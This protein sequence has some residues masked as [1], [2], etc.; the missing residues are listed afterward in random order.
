MAGRHRSFD[1]EVVL[2]TTMKVFWRNG[3]AGTSMSDLT[4]ATGLTKPSL[5]AAYGNKEA[6]FS[7]S[8]HRYIRAQR[9][10][11]GG[12]LQAPDVSLKDRIANYLK[13]SARVAADRSTPGGC[14]VANSTCEANSSAMPSEARQT[15]AEV[16]N[17]ARSRI[18]DYLRDEQ[19]KGNLAETAAPD[20]L[21]DYLLVLQSGLVLMAKKG[22]ELAAIERLI[23]HVILTWP[24]DE[25]HT[26]N[27][28]A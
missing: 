10:K 16:N 5:Y 22:T 12:E 26:T 15:I 6:L 1:K 13:A 14:F 19:A 25:P 2:E 9:E 27:E 3:F 18:T 28:H 20:L 23:D 7:L 4:G 24:L 8:L 11:T 17:N 21:A